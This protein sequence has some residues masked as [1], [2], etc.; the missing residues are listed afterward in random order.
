[1]SPEKTK[2]QPGVTTQSQVPS[3]DD[4]DVL[5]KALC[6]IP[7]LKAGKIALQRHVEELQADK[8]VLQRHVEE[9]QRDNEEWSEAMADHHCHARK[10]IK[11]QGG[12]LNVSL[13]ENHD[14]RRKYADLVEAYMVS[15]HN[16]HGSAGSA[17]PP[18]LAHAP[19]D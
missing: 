10:V 13:R 14:W 9:L 19:L 11:D 8:K 2:Q 5:K 16:S 3:Q 7:K 18:P 17:L 6:L 15:L 12:Q 4:M 1:M